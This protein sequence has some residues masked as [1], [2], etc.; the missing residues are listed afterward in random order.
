MPRLFRRWPDDAPGDLSPWKIRAMYA[1]GYAGCEWRA[2]KIKA[3]RA[4]F[5]EHIES[6]G[7]WSYANGEDAAYANGLV[8]SGVGKCSLIFPLIEQLYPGSL[9]GPAQVTGDCVSHS[10]KNADLGSLCAE[11]LAGSPDE[12]S[13]LVEGAPD[14]SPEGIRNG[15]LASEWPWYWRGYNGAG[16]QCHIAAKVSTQHGCMIRKRYSPEFDLTKYSSTSAAR[17]GRRPPPDEL[18]RIGRQHLVRTATRVSGM[19]QIRDFLSNGYA[20]AS[21]GGES[22]SRNPDAWGCASRTRSGWSHAMAYLGFIDTPEVRREYGDS[23]VHVQN[24]WGNYIQGEP[25]QVY[26]TT[27]KINRGSFFAKWSDVKNR[28]TIA[29][30]SVAGWPAKQLPDILE[31]W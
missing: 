10:Q 7:D 1:E 24:S 5:D 2:D 18:D 16:W 23:L 26:G 15:V 13:G 6:Q 28:T 4:E 27:I 17:Y 12:Q 20:I 30:S 29:M 9:P 31:G 19:E 25:R 8:G 21:C 3:A 11:V 22:F 14:V